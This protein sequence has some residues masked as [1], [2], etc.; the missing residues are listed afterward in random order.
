[1]EGQGCS[2]ASKGANERRRS[3]WAFCWH[4]MC[5]TMCGATNPHCLEKVAP[6]MYEGKWKGVFLGALPITM[7]LR[8]LRYAAGKNP[9]GLMLQ[10]SAAS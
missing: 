8:R 2:S 3:H 10:R 4:Q 6:R 5:T 9:A 7:P 1:M